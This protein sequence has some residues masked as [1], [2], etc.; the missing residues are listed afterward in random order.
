MER[1]TEQYTR[2]SRVEIEVDRKIISV[3]VEPCEDATA[4]I[5]GTLK[6]MDTLK[7]AGVVVTDADRAT[8]AAGMGSGRSRIKLGGGGK[9]YFIFVKT[10]TGSTIMLEVEDTDTTEKVKV[11]VQDKEG[12]PPDQQRLIFSGKQLQDGHTL[13]D[14]NIGKLSTVHLVLR[15][16]GQGHQCHLISENAVSVNGPISAVVT[17][18]AHDASCGSNSILQPGQDA[19]PF[20]EARDVLLSGGVIVL[21]DGA[22]LEIPADCEIDGHT[23]NISLPPPMGHFVRDDL[24]LVLKNGE[25][26]VWLAP[27]PPCKLTPIAIALNHQNIACPFLWLID[28]SNP[29]LQA[30]LTQ[31]CTELGNLNSEAGIRVFSVSKEGDIVTELESD[32]DVAL[33]ARSTL[34]F[35]C[36]NMDSFTTR[37]LVLNSVSQAECLKLMRI[38]LEMGGVFDAG[39]IDAAHEKDYPAVVQLLEQDDYRNVRQKVE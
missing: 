29:S 37:Y 12:I 14:Y 25:E 31:C 15:L 20:V 8:L 2:P 23:V 11:Q 17:F 33:L 16:R 22:G 9:G 32:R 34:R 7:A 1:D 26:V 30:L 21:Q 28:R 5:N 39:T 13:D 6:I 3:E 36:P 24:M 4:K 19:D 27:V 35:L 18:A 10:L 38:A